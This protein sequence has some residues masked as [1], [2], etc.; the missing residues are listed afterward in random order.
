VPFFLDKIY[1][2]RIEKNLATLIIQFTQDIKCVFK[3]SSILFLC[4]YS[5]GVFLLLEISQIRK[6]ALK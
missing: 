1:T 6:G 4:V 2:N 3:H 5:A